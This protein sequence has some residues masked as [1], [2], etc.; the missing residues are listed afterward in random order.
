[1]GLSRLKLRF[2][3]ALC[4]FRGSWGFVCLFVFSSSRLS[5][6]SHCL[7]SGLS[8]FKASWPSATFY[9]AFIP[10]LGL[11]IPAP[12]LRLWVISLSKCSPF[13]VRSYDYQPDS[14]LASDITERRFCGLG[15]G[16]L[17]RG[18]IRGTERIM[19]VEYRNC[20]ANERLKCKVRNK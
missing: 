10:E 16:Q 11:L 9:T 4:S 14:S 13:D 6:C 5:S 7:A 12:P 3:K 19:K 17:Q 15:W 1:M 20:F 8:V 2:G 18:I